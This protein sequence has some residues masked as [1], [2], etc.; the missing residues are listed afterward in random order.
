M[1]KNRRTRDDVLNKNGAASVRENEETEGE[2]AGRR[3]GDA[4]H[5]CAI[6]TDKARGETDG[7]G[8]TERHTQRETDRWC[9]I[10]WEVER[11]AVERSVLTAVVWLSPRDLSQPINSFWWN[12][13]THTHTHTHTQ[14][15][16]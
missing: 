14:K 15:P 3:E 11:K 12:T 4:V 2:A 7:A 10:V 13:R 16:P 1:E 8:G 9:C 6:L 5:N